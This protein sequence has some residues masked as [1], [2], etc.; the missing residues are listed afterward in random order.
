VWTGAISFGMVAIPIRLVPA[1]RKKSI[2]FNQL[3]DRNM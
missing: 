2:S 1:V 3:D